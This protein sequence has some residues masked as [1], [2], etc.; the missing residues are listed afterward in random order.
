MAGEE[1]LEL[2]KRIDKIRAIVKEADAGAINAKACK[3]APPLSM[4][5]QCNHVELFYDDEPHVSWL[6]R[7]SLAEGKFA[8]GLTCKKCIESV[9]SGLERTTC[10]VPDIVFRVPRFVVTEE[11]NKACLRE[12]AADASME[13]TPLTEKGKKLLGDQFKNDKKNGETC[14]ERLSLA[15]KE[16]S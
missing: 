3:D 13:I 14:G 1:G 7:Y 10:K 8:D 15:E 2:M 11:D 4:E 12:I 9:E 16:K 5:F 6:T